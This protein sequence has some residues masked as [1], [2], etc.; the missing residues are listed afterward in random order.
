LFGTFH[1]DV[2]CS[3]VCPL[4]LLFKT[5][6]RKSHP[7]P[8]IFYH[9]FFALRLFSLLSSC[10]REVAAGSPRQLPVLV[11]TTQKR[12]ILIGSFKF[13]NLHGGVF[14]NGRARLFFRRMSTDRKQVL[15]ND[16]KRALASYLA[17]HRVEA[18]RELPLGAILLC[19]SPRRSGIPIAWDHNKRRNN[20]GSVLLHISWIC[21]LLLDD[22]D[23]SIPTGAVRR[24]R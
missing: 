5:A 10:S 2:A 12:V 4:C 7:A 3:G 15:W 6:Q 17:Q 19:L 9:D 13:F 14:R 23:D 21:V 20:L 1:Q 11:K 22:D 16:E 24:R 18:K 8:G